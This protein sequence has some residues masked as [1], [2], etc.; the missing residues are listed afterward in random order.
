LAINPGNILPLFRS[1][2]KIPCEIIHNYSN[3]LD[4]LDEKC[5]QRRDFTW[6]NMNIHHWFLM[7]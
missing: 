7:T 6:H 2:K 1:A 5:T 3:N 4:I